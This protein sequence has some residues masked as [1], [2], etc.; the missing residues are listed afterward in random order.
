MMARRVI[1]CLLGTGWHHQR[2]AKTAAQEK[3][4]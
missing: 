2:A 3:F 1:F 4:A